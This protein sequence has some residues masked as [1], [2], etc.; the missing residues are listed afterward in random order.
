MDHELFWDGR[1]VPRP[2]GVSKPK[3]GVEG[4]DG[5]HA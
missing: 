4:H 5:N 3:F 1:E 2:P